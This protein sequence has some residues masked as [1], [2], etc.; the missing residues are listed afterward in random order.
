MAVQLVEAAAQRSASEGGRGA[1]LSVDGLANLLCSTQEGGRPSPGALLAAYYLLCR[2][3][4]QVRKRQDDY[5]TQRRKQSKRGMDMYW[6]SADDG[7]EQHGEDTLLTTMPALLFLREAQTNGYAPLYPQL[8]ELSVAHLPHLFVCSFM[9][10]S[11]EASQGAHPLLKK[12]CTSLVLLASPT[13]GTPSSSSEIRRNHESPSPQLPQQG[14]ECGIDS[15]EWIGRGEQGLSMCGR[16]SKSGTQHEL[17]QCASG[18][19]EF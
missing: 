3:G 2:R 19:R 5:Y 13:S 12:L 16:S 14:S 15:P 4:A 10:S 17:V 9:I 1:G 8:V 7:G 6:K 11:L 18:R